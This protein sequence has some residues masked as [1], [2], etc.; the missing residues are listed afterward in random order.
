[1][2]EV[3]PLV[4][5]VDNETPVQSQPTQQQLQ[6]LQPVNTEPPVIQIDALQGAIA[7]VILIGTI[8]VGWGKLKASVTHIGKQVD[9]LIDEMKDATTRLTRIESG[10]AGLT[11]TKS[12]I[13]LTEKGESALND[14]VLKEFIDGNKK[15]LVDLCE[16]GH[17]LSTAYDVQ[18]AVFA[19]MEDYHFPHEI[20]RKLKNY[21]FE[22]GL[23]MEM[24]RRVGA[25]YLRDIVIEDKGL[26]HDDID[27]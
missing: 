14:S 1:M 23:N 13:S 10:A 4:K 3:S 20:E 25:I 15:S 22:N 24:M 17:E 26:K 18:E 6:S 2:T 21:A 9:T 16:N 11:A 8:G 19:F 5:S 12:P 27:K 7:L